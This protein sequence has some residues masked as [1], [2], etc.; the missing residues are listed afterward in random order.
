[1]LLSLH[2]WL[3]GFSGWKMVST[4]YLSIVCFAK[5]KEDQVEF[6]RDSSRNW[7][8]SVLHVLSKLQ[9]KEYTLHAYIL[10]TE[11][12][13][14]LPRTQCRCKGKAGIQNYLDKMKMWL[15]EIES[16]FTFQSS[17]L[18]SKKAISQTGRIF[19]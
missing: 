6:W 13:I 5:R 12:D 1:M 14:K 11:G 16:N 7:F 10:Y 8:L 18:H 15:G 3:L 19:R 9:T 4:E 17:Q 2:S